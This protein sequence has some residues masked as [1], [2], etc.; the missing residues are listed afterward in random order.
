MEA[1]KR[2]NAGY[3]LVEVIVVIAILG[4]MTGVVTISMS[5]LNSKDSEEC[6][7]MI[8]SQLSML[9]TYSM[10]KSDDWRM[11]IEQDSSTG[12]NQLTV[13][14]NNGSSD[15]VY[16]SMDLSKK[17]T[18]AALPIVIT[19]D[20]A[21]GS[22]K[23]VSKAGTAVNLAANEVTTIQIT[24]NHGTKRADI[25]LVTATGRHYVD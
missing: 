24:N 18:I 15:T 10:S 22:V 8:D 2:R 19:F 23:S 5:V 1:K 3:S 16:E 12:M 11:E 13:Y 14:R 7:T 17:V 20:K 21:N 25:N 4:I 6:A 9:R